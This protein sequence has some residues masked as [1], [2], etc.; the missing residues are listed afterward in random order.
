VVLASFIGLNRLD[1]IALDERSSL[2]V[3]HFSKGHFNLVY[4]QWQ[5]AFQLKQKQPNSLYVIYLLLEGAI[6]LRINQYQSIFCSFDSSA[7]I[8]NPDQELVAIASEQGQALL[9]CIEGNVL[10]Q[11]L[12]R[13][14]GQSLKR[15]VIFEPEIDLTHELGGSLKQFVEFLWQLEGE[16]TSSPLVVEELEQAFLDCLLR[17][18]PHNYSEFLLYQRIG[19]LACYVRKAQ[20]FIEANIQENICLRDLVAVVG[21]SPR[22]LEKAFAHHCNCSPMKFLRGV[23][24]DRVRRELEQGSPQTKVSEV[25]IRYGFCHGGKFAHEYRERFGETPSETLKRSQKISLP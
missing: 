18:L 5:R 10:E 6:D 1:S 9:I 12:R 25:M 16:T 21:V 7:A 22:M 15:P 3:C 20:A 24:L 13:L 11:A 14:I 23:R 2:Q 4:L 8:V 19:T 17:G